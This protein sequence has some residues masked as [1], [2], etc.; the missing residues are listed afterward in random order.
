MMQDTC[1]LHRQQQQETWTTTMAQA[2]MDPYPLAFVGD[3][4][5]CISNDNP[6]TSPLSP[7]ETPTVNTGNDWETSVRIGVHDGKELKQARAI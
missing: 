4:S 5:H 1:Y 2:Q 6:S 7:T 3:G